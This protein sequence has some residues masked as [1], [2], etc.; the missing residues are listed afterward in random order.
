[1]KFIV[2][3]VKNINYKYKVIDTINSTDDIQKFK[4]SLEFVD[5]FMCCKEITQKLT[6]YTKDKGKQIYEFIG[7]KNKDNKLIL[8]F[9][10]HNK[11]LLATLP[12]F[13]INL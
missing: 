2:F 1:M 8:K 11:L 6:E 5:T 7:N 3:G 9:N 13:R 4:N 10:Y 12:E